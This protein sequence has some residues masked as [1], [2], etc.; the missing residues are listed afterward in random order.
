MPTS[1]GCFGIAVNA[2]G[3]FDFGD[4]RPEVWMQASRFRAVPHTVTGLTPV[5][6]RTR[7]P[8]FPAITMRDLKPDTRWSDWTWA[9][10]NVTVN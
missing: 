3:S 4:R 10:V 1:I 8:S 6:K 2:D 7:S 5:A 9:A